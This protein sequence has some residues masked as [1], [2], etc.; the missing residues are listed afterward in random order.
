MTTSVM[1]EWK[2]TMSEF[3]P[4]TEWTD[5]VRSA[6]HVVMLLTRGCVDN[7]TRSAALLEEAASARKTIHF[8]YIEGGDSFGD[9]S[10]DFGVFY[11]LHKESPSPATRSVASHEALKY[12]AA[13]PQAI[14]YEHDAMVLEML[15]RMRGGT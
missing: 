5:G 1:V 11:S 8:L 3:A 9:E 4:M 15:Q 6:N 7:G 14:R 12:R 10:L 13:T 2:K